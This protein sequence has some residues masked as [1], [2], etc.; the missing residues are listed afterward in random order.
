[1]S[2][3][4]ADSTRK[5]IISMFKD[6]GLSITIE[7]NLHRTEFLDVTLDLNTGKFFPYR[8]PN[9]VPLYIDVRSN[10]PPNIIKQ[11]PS[12]ISKRI[13]DNSCNIEE[14]DKSKPVYQ[15]ALKKSGYTEGM[16]Y[17]T[18][19]RKSNNRKRNVIW[20][21]PPYSMNVRTNIGIRFL[22][23][24][25]KHFPANHK[26]HKIF[27]KNSLKISYC[28]MPNVG[29]LINK[30]NSQTLSEKTT[31]KRNV[32]NC[33]N[34]STCPLDGNCQQNCLIYKAS[35]S[36]DDK[37]MVYYGL[38]EPAF[39]TRFGNHKHSFNNRSL[40]KSTELSK[41]IWSLKDANKE[42]SIKWSVA[43]TAKPY[44]CGNKLCDLCIMEKLKIAQADPDTL[45]NKRS[46]IMNKCRHRNK[47]SLKSTKK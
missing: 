40:E 15:D 46:E 31:P 5:K 20:F 41:Y 37:M 34:K 36:S 19:S 7:T 13:S 17:Q 12:M 6:N 22:K 28:C 14:F 33:H 16:K 47:F 30:H 35:V 38:S 24:V 3:P 11:L 8:K 25:A 43:A 26:F 23:S 42:F 10:H 18:Q 9:D 44:Q 1:M 29:S 21:N 2:G 39:K 32:C 27:N 45:L 4:E